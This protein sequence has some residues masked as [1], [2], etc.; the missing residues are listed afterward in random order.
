MF[1]LA[2]MAGWDGLNIDER[3]DDYPIHWQTQP[4]QQGLRTA[5][6]S[7]IGRDWKYECLCQYQ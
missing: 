3:N 6:I 7:R 1:V 4:Y 5:G 2:L